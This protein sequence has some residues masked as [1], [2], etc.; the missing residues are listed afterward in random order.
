MQL[1]FCY[2]Q[3][4]P[5]HLAVHQLDAG[6]GRRDAGRLRVVAA[7]QGLTLVHVTAQLEQ[8][9]DTLMS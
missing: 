9:Q 5:P 7:D 8:L 2:C 1:G 6:G 3:P 4:A